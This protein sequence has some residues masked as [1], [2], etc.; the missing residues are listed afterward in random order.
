[1]PLATLVPVALPVMTELPNCT[2]APLTLM[3]V[4]LLEET[5]WLSI[6][7]VDCPPLADAL[8]PAPAFPAASLSFTLILIAP[9]V[10]V[11]SPRMPVML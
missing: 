8:K 9:V 1:M 6:I 2:V 11:P 10:A 7:S 4:P 5:T 3:P